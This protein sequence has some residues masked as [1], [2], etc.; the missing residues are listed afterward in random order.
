MKEHRDACEKGILEK[1]AVA[2]HVWEKHHSK[3]ALHIEMIPAEECFNHDRGLKLSNCW[4]A[5]E[6]TGGWR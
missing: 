6:E 2:E 4:M 3:V 5:T 1:S